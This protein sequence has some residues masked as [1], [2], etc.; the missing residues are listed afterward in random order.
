MTVE[1]LRTS[2]RG[3]AVILQINR[4]ED[5]NRIDEATMLA[6]TAE[7]K[8]AARTDARSVIITGAGEKF[9]CGGRIG[10]FPEGSVEQQLTYARA[11]TELME[12][13]GR[14]S[15]PV[16]A[17]VNG[18][19]LAGGMSLLECC[20]VAVTVDS[21]SFGYPEVNGGLFPMLAI[22]VARTSLPPKLAFDLFY[23][24]RRIDAAAAAAVHLV[25][26]VVPAS[27][28]D[29]AVDRWV[30]D[31]AGKRGSSLMVGRQAWSAMDGMTRSQA[32]EYAQAALVTMLAAA[33]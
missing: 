25:N 27:G 29:E 33:K 20:D 21:A 16:I 19:C 1:T 8:A 13:I 11:F 10:G 23:T 24:G 9:C 30:D 31:L 32:L 14:S 4:P 18:D 5:D 15:I 26:E 6:M 7:L 17:A 3:N 12:A 2:R 28:L 22:A